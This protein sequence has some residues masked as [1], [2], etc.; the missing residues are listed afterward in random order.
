M[1]KLYVSYRFSLINL[2]LI[3]RIFYGKIILLFILF[4]GVE[5]LW[6]QID[7]EG[8]ALINP[9]SRTISVNQQI[10]YFNKSQDTLQSFY[11]NDWNNAFKSKI[12]PLGKHFSSTYL[13]RFQF[14]NRSERGETKVDFIKR[15]EEH[16][17]ELQS[18]GHLVCR[19]LL[20][21]K[22]TKSRRQ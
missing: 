2:S 7:I 4:F 18:R 13:R 17:S 14:S 6:A 10:T 12:S 20:E 1:R 16:T 11:L 3:K 22:K 19:L 15:S 8:E 5:N 9:A 21:K